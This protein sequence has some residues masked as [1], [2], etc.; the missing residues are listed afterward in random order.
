[1]SN[2]RLALAPF[3]CRGQAPVQGDPKAPKEITASL[4]QPSL[5]FHVRKHAWALPGAI[6]SLSPLGPARARGTSR[7]DHR[8]YYRDDTTVYS[9]EHARTAV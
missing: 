9:R 1:M 4:F 6:T 5:N 8:V 7:E 2:R 3:F